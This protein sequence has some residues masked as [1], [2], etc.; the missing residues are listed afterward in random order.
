MARI[1]AQTFKSLIVSSIVVGGAIGVMVALRHGLRNGLTAAAFTALGW[2]GLMAITM[3]F[4]QLILTRKLTSEQSHP[5]QSCEFE[6]SG[7]VSAVMELLVKSLSELRFVHNISVNETDGVISARTRGSFVSFGE[8]ISIKVTGVGKDQVSI[9][10]S[11]APAIRFTVLDYGKNHRN[12]EAIRRMMRSLGAEFV[13]SSCKLDD[14][15]SL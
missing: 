12:I 11:S 1:K 7:S 10:L 9:K 13:D 14:R 3:G 2:G 5:E 8:Q 6:V 4:L 15:G